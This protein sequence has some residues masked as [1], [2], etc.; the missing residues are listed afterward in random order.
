M[1]LQFVET[2]YIIY[3]ECKPSLIFCLLVPFPER[4]WM[5]T[6][7]ESFSET[8]SS[9]SKKENRLES[10]ATNFYFIFSMRYNSDGFGNRQR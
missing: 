7:G 1:S 4:I 3:K 9:V 10:G 2:Q 8:L 6:V 5:A